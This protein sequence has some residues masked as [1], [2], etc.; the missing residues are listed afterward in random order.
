MD[1]VGTAGGDDLFFVMR[2]FSQKL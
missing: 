2:H 1:V